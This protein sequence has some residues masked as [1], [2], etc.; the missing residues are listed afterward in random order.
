MINFTPINIKMIESPRDRYTKR[1][2]SPFTRKY[3]ARRPRSAKA[4]AEKTKK[5]SDVTPKVAGI[6][7]RAK[8][9]SVDAIATMTINIGV[10]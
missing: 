4:L 6:E 9:K 3:K 2:K 5:V 1:S 7:S 10:A 8:S